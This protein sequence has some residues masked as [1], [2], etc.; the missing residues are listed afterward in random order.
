VLL[1]EDF[2]NTD[3]WHKV[4]TDG[5][6]EAL[7]CLWRYYWQL[8]IDYHVEF[9][10]Y[11]TGVHQELYTVADSGECEP[12]ISGIEFENQHGRPTGLSIFVNLRQQPVTG[13]CSPTRPSR[14][15][16]SWTGT[17]FQRVTKSKMMER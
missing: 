15:R 12:L 14:L 1:D 11:R 7:V 16:F 3:S 17:T 5:G 2:S 4:R 13:T 9:H 6:R 10:N 8:G